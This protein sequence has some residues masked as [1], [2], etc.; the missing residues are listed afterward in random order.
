VDIAVTLEGTRNQP[1][2]RVSSSPSLPQPQ[3]LLALATNKTWQDTKEQIRQGTVS[4]DTVKEFIDYFAFAGTGESL[5]QRLGF[6]NISVTYQD[7]TKGLSVT[8]ELTD[9]IDAT[10]AVEQT[11]PEDGPVTTDQKIGGEIKINQNLSIGAS[12]ELPDQTQNQQTQGQEAETAEEEVF[13][14][15][16]KTF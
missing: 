9:R 1:D 8:R 4:A 12:K 13:F 16:Q 7:Q 10:Y 3:L 6:K 2:L 14:K 11:R 5:A 15:F